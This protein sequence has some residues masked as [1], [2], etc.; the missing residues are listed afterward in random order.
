MDEIKFY[1]KTEEGATKIADTINLKDE[2]IL[3]GL[4]GEKCRFTVDEI[5]HNYNTGSASSGDMLVFLT[6]REDGWYAKH[7]FVNKKVLDLIKIV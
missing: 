5:N 7:T 6:K 2:F 4:F 3:R 1:A